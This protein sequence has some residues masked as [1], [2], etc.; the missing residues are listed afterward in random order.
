MIGRSMKLKIDGHTLDAVLNKP[1][2][3]A[4]NQ[5]EAGKKSP[6]LIIIHGFTGEKNEPHL[7]AVDK[8]AR[9]LGFVTLR[10]DMY[11]HGASEGQFC[12]HTLYKWVTDLVEIIDY[13]A[14]LDFVGDIFLCGHSQGALCAMMTAGIKHDMIRALLPLSP[15]WTIP[16]NA[17]KGDL[18]GIR[19]DPDD[20]PDR[21]CLWDDY[22]IGS[23]YLRIAQT[24]YVEPMIE[25]YTGPV[26]IAHG[27]KDA[28]IPV[29]KSH[30]LSKKYGDCT[31]VTIPGDTHCFDFHTDLMATALHDWL[32]T[33]S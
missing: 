4:E 7:I 29:E 19:F 18:L 20:I 24:I 15:A 32:K 17:R 30:E 10:V 22:C 8:V 31:L 14:S 28:T 9:E 11:G 23:N 16:E 6:I 33:V 21:I 2:Q 12:D 25:K 3:G 27:E 1:S 13:V 5:S 26:F